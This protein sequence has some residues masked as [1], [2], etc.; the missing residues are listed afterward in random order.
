MSDK[1]QG[2]SQKVIRLADLP[3]L[4]QDDI[5]LILE[6]I[7]TQEGLLNGPSHSENAAES[8]EGD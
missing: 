8:R 3:D 6:Y 5:R 7:A 1:E 2:S 4:I